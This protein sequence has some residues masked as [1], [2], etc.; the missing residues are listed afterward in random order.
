MSEYLREKAPP[1]KAVK[2][3]KPL[4]CSKMRSLFAVFITLMSLHLLQLFLFLN[5]VTLEVVMHMISH[6]INI[7]ASKKL[8]EKQLKF[9]FYCRDNSVFLKVSVSAVIQLVP[10]WNIL[11]QNMHM[12]MSKKFSAQSI[13]HSPQN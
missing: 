5:A 13:H 2:G 3:M 12:C 4:G 1:V 10:H 9:I 6:I 7:M 8:L 11:L